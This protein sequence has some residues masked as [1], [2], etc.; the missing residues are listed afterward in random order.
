MNIQQRI[1]KNMHTLL[2]PNNNRNSMSKYLSLFVFTLIF[3]LSVNSQDVLQSMAEESCNCMDELDPKSTASEVETKFGLC[4]VASAGL[5]MEELESQY[6]IN[7]SKNPSKAGKK[8]GEL[9]GMRMINECPGYLT[10]L[11]GQGSFKDA[12]EERL[13]KKQKIQ[14]AESVINNSS[15]SSGSSS[16]SGKFVRLEKNQFYNLVVED[17][18]GNTYKLLWLGSFEGSEVLLDESKVGQLIEVNY[19]EEALFNAEHSEYID[20]KIITGVTFK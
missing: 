11:A 14:E 12:Q 1:F 10:F 4:M 3:S 18:S 5:Y 7:F 6:D 9:V 13:R 2:Q 17:K 15:S 16:I 19:E 20:Q 8:L